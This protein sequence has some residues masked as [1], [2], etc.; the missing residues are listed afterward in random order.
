MTRKGITLRIRRYSY[1]E[2]VDVAPVLWLKWFNWKTLD[3]VG[4]V[5]GENGWYMR[6]QRRHG[7]A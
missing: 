1:P 2:W 6:A 7:G 5:E 4:H 3:G